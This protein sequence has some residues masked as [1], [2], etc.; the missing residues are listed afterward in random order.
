MYIKKVA[1]QPGTGRHSVT[2][3][4]GYQASQESPFFGNSPRHRAEPPGAK[5]VL[6]DLGP[7]SPKAPVI[8]DCSRVTHTITL[9]KSN[10][11]P[12]NLEPV[13][14]QDPSLGFAG[15]KSQRTLREAP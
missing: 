12:K 7:H 1:D 9:E 4:G 5:S 10:L 14:R 8:R 11:L 13:R 15:A 6:C 3:W 2:K